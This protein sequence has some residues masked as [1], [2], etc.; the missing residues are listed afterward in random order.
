MYH[1]HKRLSLQTLL[2]KLALYGSGIS[3]SEAFAPLSV[4][5]VPSSTVAKQMEVLNYMVSETFESYGEEAPIYGS[6]V[7]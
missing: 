2:K 4:D 1:V 3:F 6:Y 5:Q 7:L